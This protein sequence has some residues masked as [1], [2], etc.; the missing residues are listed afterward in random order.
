MFFFCL[1]SSFTFHPISVSASQS[2]VYFFAISS[3]FTLAC[4]IVCI[5]FE[6]VLEFVRFSYINK[7]FW[8]ACVSI[9]QCIRTQRQAKAN[10][11]LVIR[12]TNNLINS[13]PLIRTV[14]LTD[15]QYLHKEH[16]HTHTLYL[17]I[18]IYNAVGQLCLEW[19]QMSDHLFVFLE[20]KKVKIIHHEHLE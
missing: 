15:Q 10:K 3:Q 17:S 9:Q 1:F 5:W 20:L 6:C 2:R 8:C 7:M 11:V 14:F 18:Y 13:G 16:T 4:P 19:K 12:T